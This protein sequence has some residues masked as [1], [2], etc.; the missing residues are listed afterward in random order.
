MDTVS[1][2]NFLKA[3]SPTEYRSAFAKSQLYTYTTI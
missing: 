3:T 2:N 1:I